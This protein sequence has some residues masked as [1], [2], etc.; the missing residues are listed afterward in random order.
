MIRCE[1]EQQDHY[2]VL[3]SSPVSFKARGA[4]N[5]LMLLTPV[6]LSMHHRVVYVIVISHPTMAMLLLVYSM[7]WLFCLCMYDADLPSTYLCITET[8]QFPCMLWHDPFSCIWQAVAGRIKHQRDIHVLHFSRG[9]GYCSAFT[10]TTNTF[11]PPTL[12]ETTICVK[13]QRIHDGGLKQVLNRVMSYKYMHVA[14]PKMNIK[15]LSE[16]M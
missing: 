6:R 13:W 3:Y 10:V 7:M 2:F 14:S 5:T 8:Y 9:G 1:T 15:H 11:D 16:K 12:K 4:C